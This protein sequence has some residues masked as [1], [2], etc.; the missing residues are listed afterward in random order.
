MAELVPVTITA[1]VRE[2]ND[3]PGRAERFAIELAAAA[4]GDTRRVR[5]GVGD[6]EAAALAFSL[7]GQQ[8]PRPMTYQLMASLVGAAGSA[9]RAVRVTGRR[10]DGIFYAQVLL[11][12]GAVVDARP[13]DALN[14]AAVTGAPVTV[15]EELL[16]P[17]PVSRLGRCPACGAGG[18]LLG[19]APRRP[20][21]LGAGGLPQQRARPVMAVAVPVLE[22]VE[23]AHQGAGAPLAPP[24]ERA[25]RVVDAQAHRGVDVRFA[26]DLAG[27]RVEGEV[28]AG[29]RP[30]RPPP[31][32]GSPHSRKSRWQWRWPG[33]GPGR[34]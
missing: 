29:G 20:Q 22:V 7:Q 27:E 28:G 6:A 19:V 15:A 3:G 16:G 13:S 21:P 1:V 18:H 5:I 14:L 26:R 34:R 17:A 9:V 32:R 2:G 23:D 33:P 30:P 24:G 10:G 4:E 11:R 8:F 12:G 25:A 31:P